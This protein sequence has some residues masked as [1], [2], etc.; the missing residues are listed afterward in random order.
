[1]LSARGSRHRTPLWATR[2]SSREGGKDEGIYG[3]DWVEVA[4]PRLI[5][6][7]KEGH[8]DDRLI[9]RYLT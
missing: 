5:L 8:V 9:K 6:P 4:R 2:L 1:M 3:S 7:V